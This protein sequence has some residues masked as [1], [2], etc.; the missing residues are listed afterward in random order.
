[1]AI[2]ENVDTNGYP[3]FYFLNIHGGGWEHDLMKIIVD[4]FYPERIER[5]LYK[6]GWHSSESEIIF[7]KN[8][9]TYSV[10]LDEMD[11]I[12]FRAV[13]DNF[14]IDVTREF[15]RILDL[16]SEKTDMKRRQSIK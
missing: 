16:E 14:N 15:A 12:K 3:S 1:M 9:V 11:G 6:A 8:N 13:S 7:I 5:K 2:K 10:F 4:S